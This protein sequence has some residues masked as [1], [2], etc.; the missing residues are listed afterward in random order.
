[1]SKSIK[2]V[3]LINYY[4]PPSGGPAVQRWV[5][6]A[7]LLLKENIQTTVVTID[8][9]VATFPLLD[10]SLNEK[11]PDKIAVHKTDTSEL[12]WLY[13]KVTGKK[14][15]KPV[16]LSNEKKEGFKQKVAKFI[17]GNLFLPD[18]RRG[19]GKHAYAKAK[20]L[21][22]SEE[23]T[24]VITAGPP[25]S[26]HL[27]GLKL[28]KEL[29]VNW[30]ADFHDEWTDHWVLKQFYRTALANYFDRL[31]EKKVLNSADVV[32]SHCQAAKELLE[33]KISEK[34]K[35][36][37][38]IIYMGY[39]EDYFQNITQKQSNEFK[40]VYTGTIGKSYHPETFFKALRK[41]ISKFNHL[42]IKFVFAGM[43]ASE[44]QHSIK[45]I[46]VEQYIENLG[47]ISHEEAIEV[48][49]SG[50]LLLLMNPIFDGEQ[51]ILPGKLFE[52]LAVKTPVLNLAS[53][54]GQSAQI[55]NKS[56]A[57][58]SFAHHSE[59]EIEEYLEKQI[60]SWEENNR[61][62]HLNENDISIY[63]RQ[64]AVEQLREII[65]KM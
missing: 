2:K 16:G 6:F 38:R 42:T 27:V 33:S 18:P 11:V 15:V 60:N 25:Q 30:I 36:K 21:L 7:R 26:T 35:H 59:K 14:S 13:K 51:R 1:M 58:K 50:N 19:W 31:L 53:P 12:F 41:V 39:D 55:I 56:H 10:D 61:I 47:Y 63:S 9:K 20:E 46:G 43:M 4:W 3:L 48:L 29:G 44:I 40:I 52:Y 34:V 64:F 57:G 8:E 45:E 17:R 22:L 54:D 23:Y 65:D 49:K 28:K 62:T 32:L 24:C 5:D 37:F